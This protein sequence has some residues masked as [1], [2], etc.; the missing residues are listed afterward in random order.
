MLH[1]ELIL[2][3]ITAALV[4]GGS[5]TLRLV[6]K[7]RE[8]GIA[9]FP[10]QWPNGFSRDNE[11]WKYHYTLVLHTVI[12]WMCYVMAAVAVVTAVVKL[13]SGMIA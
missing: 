1:G 4:W 2:L 13:I 12:A 8:T 7:A 6:R 10:I 3:A 9:D 5:V 11:P